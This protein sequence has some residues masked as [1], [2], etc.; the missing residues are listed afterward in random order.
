ML[1]QPPVE[2]AEC[3]YVMTVAAVDPEPVEG[4]EGFN[5]VYWCARK[6][7]TEL[8]WLCLDTKKIPV[9]ATIKSSCSGFS[10]DLDFGFIP[11]LSEVLCSVIQLQ[12]SI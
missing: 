12:Y 7:P 1:Q 10:L 9:E 8:H 5:E 3:T 6:V 11:P 2:V 4:K